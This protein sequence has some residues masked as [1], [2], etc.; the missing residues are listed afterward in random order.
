MRR[1]WR[2]QKRKTHVASIE[3]KSIDTNLD[4][5]GNGVS[6]PNSNAFVFPLNNVNSGDTFFTRQGLQTVPKYLRMNAKFLPNFA[7]YPI[8]EAAFPVFNY[9]RLIVFYDK[10]PNNVI[11]NDLPSLLQ[12]VDANG[13]V[14]PLSPNTGYNR[15]GSDRFIVLLDDFFTLV[16]PDGTNPAVD[17]MTS[18]RDWFNNKVVRRLPTKFLNNGPTVPPPPVPPQNNTQVTTG[19]FYVLFFPSVATSKD[20]AGGGSTMT[21][22]ARYKFTEG[23]L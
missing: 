4:V 20:V 10:Q 16:I 23:K 18:Q 14:L 1:G 15:S 8:A 5:V 3:N 6:V 11:F 17:P 22:T 13:L 12:D 7:T 2:V 9:I 19:A 21:G